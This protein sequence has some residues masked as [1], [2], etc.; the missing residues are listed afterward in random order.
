MIEPP[1]PWGRPVSSGASAG[2]VASTARRLLWSPEAVESPAAA[3]V[4]PAPPALPPAPVTTAVAARPMA[5]IGATTTPAALTL[6]ATAAKQQN[7]IQRWDSLT[8]PALL[9]T[10]RTSSCQVQLFTPPNKTGVAWRTQLWLLSDTVCQIGRR[11]PS[12][13][14]ASR[15][16][17]AESRKTTAKISS[18]Q[19]RCGALET[20]S[21]GRRPAKPRSLWQNPDLTVFTLTGAKIGPVRAARWQKWKSMWLC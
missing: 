12:A 14:M 9:R 20:E 8:S 1:P 2:T 7:Q 5:A 4:S 16:M 11:P 10:T 21:D 18:I 19:R 17:S 6:T 15:W 3:A 13:S